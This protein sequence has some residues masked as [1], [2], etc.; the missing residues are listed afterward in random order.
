MKKVLLLLVSV[1][2]VITGCKLYF[3]IDK[4]SSHV[5]LSEGMDTN[6]VLVNIGEG[7]RAYVAKVLDNI[8]TYN[9]LAIGV[10]AFFLNRKDSIGD[11][12]LQKSLRNP[13]VVIGI[14]T[15][16]T[17][18]YGT[19]IFF[20]KNVKMGVAMLNLKNNYADNYQLQYLSNYGMIDHISIALAKTVNKEKTDSFLEMKQNLVVPIL[21]SRL[22]NQFTYYEYGNLDFKNSDIEGKVILL[23]YLGPN[24]ED[25]FKTYS[26]GYNSNI[27]SEYPDMY[28]C[29]IIANQIRMVLDND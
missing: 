2:I 6:I 11:F 28:G 17:K 10:D 8:S 13:K 23:G 16:G 25:K 9:P 3:T 14:K 24:D 15:N 18:L 12:R 19:N 26:S 1:I 21:I 4:L 22:K 29:T 5:D 7:N 27:E 20:T